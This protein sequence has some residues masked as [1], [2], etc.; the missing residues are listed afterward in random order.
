MQIQ[1]NTD[2]NIEG[3]EEFAS[4][5]ELVVQDALGRFRG[6]ISRVEVHVSDQRGA[7]VEQPSEHKSEHDKR[8]MIE[9]RL[10]GRRPTAVTHDAATVD[11]AVRGAAEKLARVIEHTTQ[12]LGGRH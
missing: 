5:V 12:R 9:A 8:C 11:K 4:G 2:H 7:K 6:L 10:E 3:T 1:V